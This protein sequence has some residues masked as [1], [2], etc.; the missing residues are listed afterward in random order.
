MTRI[1]LIRKSTPYFAIT[2]NMLNIIPRLLEN[3]AVINFSEKKREWKKSAP[4]YFV[5]FQTN[6]IHYLSASP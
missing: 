6:L 3:S 2:F 4:T 1:F 5:E